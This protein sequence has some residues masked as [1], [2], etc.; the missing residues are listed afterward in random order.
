MEL[1]TQ[2]QVQ[3]CKYY[4][5]LLDK[6]NTGQLSSK[7]MGTV[8]KS[9]GL[10]ISETELKSLLNE[11]NSGAEQTKKELI[12]FPDFLTLLSRK[13]KDI[14]TDTEL[15][16]LFSELDKSGKGYI[17]V[18]DLKLMKQTVGEKFTQDELAEMLSEADVDH[19][20]VLKYE[21]FVKMMLSQ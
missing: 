11:I 16:K 14:D 18:E 2:D 9:I 15:H 10:N 20:G 1:L 8:F 13:M 17:N 5:D 6:N 21:D 19:D 12:D 4:F 3:E 7:E